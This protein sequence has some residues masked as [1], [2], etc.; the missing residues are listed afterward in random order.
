MVVWEKLHDSR[1]FY[2]FISLLVI[3]EAACSAFVQY[4]EFIFLFYGVHA[5]GLGLKA[6]CQIIK[7][8]LYIEQYPW[9]QLG[10]FC[11]NVYSYH[12]YFI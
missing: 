11:V 6:F 9:R 7:W 5:Y 2:L 1:E 4:T 10:C 3:D 8:Y 12:D